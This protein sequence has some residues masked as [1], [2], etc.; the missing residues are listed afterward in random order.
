MG[1]WNNEGNGIWKSEGVDRCFKTAQYIYIYIYI[2]TKHRK[3]LQTIAYYFHD[4]TK[5]IN[6][7]LCS[8]EFINL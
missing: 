7:P 5:K 2:Y 1:E 3:S 6:S 8:T 4:S